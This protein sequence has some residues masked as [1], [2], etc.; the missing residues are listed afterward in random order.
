MNVFRANESILINCCTEKQNKNKSK[1][2]F[3]RVTE[4][5]LKTEESINAYDKRLFKT[6]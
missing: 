1:K 5:Y 2:W 4:K 6:K 3:V